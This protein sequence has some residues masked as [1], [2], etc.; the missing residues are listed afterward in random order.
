MSYQMP[1]FE[2][3]INHA[4]AKSRKQK[5]SKAKSG[6]ESRTTSEEKQVFLPLSDTID[7]RSPQNTNPND[8]RQMVNRYINHNFSIPGPG[9]IKLRG[10]RIDRGDVENLLRPG[11]EELFI[12]FG[13]KTNGEMTTVM[14]GLE[15]N[16]MQ[17]NP[18]THAVVD[19]MNPCPHS[20][21]DNL[22]EQLADLI[23]VK[24]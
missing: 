10:T 22:E 5:P 3:H 12:L 19:V 1:S 18:A 15:N 24:K 23:S 16:L 13:L 4:P 11:I 8:G 7:W 21:P 17:T 2:K 9:G 6:E 14:V 20:C